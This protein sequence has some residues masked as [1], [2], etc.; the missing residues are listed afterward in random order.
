VQ[1][2]DGRATKGEHRGVDITSSLLRCFARIKRGLGWITELSLL[3]IWEHALDLV[4]QS[5]HGILRPNEE[6]G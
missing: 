1:D 6:L 5:L 2:G 3:K 4:D